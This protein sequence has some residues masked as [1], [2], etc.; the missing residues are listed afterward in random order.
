MEIFNEKGEPAQ[1][2]DKVSKII[3]GDI[4][5]VQDNPENMPTFGEGTV[6]FGGKQCLSSSEDKNRWEYDGEIFEYHPLPNEDDALEI[7]KYLREK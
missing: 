4:I 2:G 1:K 3:A 7:E 5:L 6:V